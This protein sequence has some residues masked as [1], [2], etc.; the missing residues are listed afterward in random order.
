MYILS[1]GII[2][3]TED[4]FKDI[5]EITLNGVVELDVHWQTLKNIFLDKNKAEILERVGSV[6]FSW[7]HFSD[8]VVKCAVNEI[9]GVF[10]EESL[11]RVGYRCNIRTVLKLF[12]Q[13][14]YST[15]EFEALKGRLRI[16]K[17]LKRADY[18][19][20]NDMRGVLKSFNKTFGKIKQLKHYKRIDAYRHKYIHKHSLPI[21][22]VFL[23]DIRIV[24]HSACKLMSDIYFV[25][26]DIGNPCK[27]YNDKDP[28]RVTFL[29]LKKAIEF[30][31]LMRELEFKDLTEEEIRGVVESILNI[32]AY[33]HKIY[34]VRS[35]D[36][37]YSYAPMEIKQRRK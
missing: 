6:D 19:K 4:Q 28:G 18:S 3:I 15:E 25:I 1:D 13:K 9:R 23:K 22:D 34:G 26:N 33:S 24:A 11:Y 12:K 20:I 30:I 37:Y 5:L 31:D 36:M 29:Y 21:D 7:R 35:I 27:I 8:S 16:V 2:D 10:E 32:D 14:K 17:R